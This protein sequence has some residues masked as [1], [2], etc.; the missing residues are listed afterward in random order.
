MMNATEFF[1]TIFRRI[2]EMVMYLLCTF[3]LVIGFYSECS[4]IFEWPMPLGIPTSLG[5]C[6]LLFIPVTIVGYI[7]LHRLTNT[8]IINRLI[9]ALIMLLTPLYVAYKIGLQK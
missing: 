5:K 3:Y 2:D 9:N 6:M 1:K 8:G 4:N 7:K